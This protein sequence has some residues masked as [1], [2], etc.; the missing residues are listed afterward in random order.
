MAIIMCPE[1]GGK[2]SDTLDA[3]PHCGYRF[4]ETESSYSSVKKY[5]SKQVVLANRNRNGTA[6]GAGIFLIVFGLFFVIAIIG[7]FLVIL[8]INNISEAKANNE[9]RHECAYYDLE[10]KKIILY[11]YDGVKHIVEPSDIIYAS[12]P[13]GTEN[14]MV[15]LSNQN[16]KI[17]CGNCPKQGVRRFNEYLEQIKEGSF[18]PSLLEE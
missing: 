10:K 15:K 16:K 14:M 17:D 5:Q 8:G 11:S 12:H 7:I 3:C 18:D 13:A 9:N 2:V 1:C 4:K 6:T